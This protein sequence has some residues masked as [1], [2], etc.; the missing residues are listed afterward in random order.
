M[1]KRTKGIIIAIA[2]ILFHITLH[3]CLVCDKIDVARRMSHW[4]HSSLC[5]R[6]DL[7]TDG[8]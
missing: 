4:T 5:I 7:A 6:K 3:V 8:I 1:K 2:A